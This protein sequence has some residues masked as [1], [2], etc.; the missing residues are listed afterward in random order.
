MENFKKNLP[1]I[2]KQNHPTFEIVVVDDHST[3]ETMPVLMQLKQ[4]IPNL[5]IV[6]KE[7]VE[8][9]NGKKQALYSGVQAAKYQ[10]IVVTDADCYPNS[11]DWLQMMVAPL[12]NPKNEL[13]LGVSPNEKAIGFWQGFFRFETYYTA[14]QYVSFALRKLPYMG[15]GRNMCYT[16]AYFLKHFP[17]VLEGDLASGDDD[18]LVNFGADKEN[19]ALVFHVDAFTYSPVPTDLAQWFRQK[20]RHLSAGYVYKFIHK[21]WLVGL[22]ASSYFLW[23]FGA[24]LLFSPVKS[25]VM[26]LLLFQYMSLS[27]IHVIGLKKIGIKDLSLEVPLYLFLW[28][29][30][31]PY[32]SFSSRLKKVIHWN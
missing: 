18:L 20:T 12:E 27:I 15:V 30:L 9:R 11:G 19:T 10:N 4:T 5:T 24:V 7:D 17:E 32:F 13:V 2:A 3:D 23:V 25:L 21:F 6:S 31:T 14:I 8:N 28:T 22:H 26:I 29:V 1:I 16:K